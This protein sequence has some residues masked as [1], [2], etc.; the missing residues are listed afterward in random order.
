VVAKIKAEENG[1]EELRP[2]AKAEAGV[3]EE[4]VED[5]V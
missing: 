1:E 3:E 4:N 5:R 2:E